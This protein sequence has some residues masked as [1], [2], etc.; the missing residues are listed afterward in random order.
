MTFDARSGRRGR[1]VARRR[2]AKASIPH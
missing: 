2:H 1:S